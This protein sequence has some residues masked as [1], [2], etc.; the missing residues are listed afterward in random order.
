MDLSAI[1]QQIAILRER[2]NSLPEIRDYKV[3]ARGK[4]KASVEVVS[5]AGA[6]E[7]FAGLFTTEESDDKGT[8][9]PGNPTDN[10]TSKGVSGSGT[11]I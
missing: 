1:E 8:D 7:I 3:Q 9:E 10:P 2:R 5:S 11:D 6:E 4:A